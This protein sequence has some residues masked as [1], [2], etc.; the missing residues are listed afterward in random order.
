MMGGE[1]GGLVVEREWPRKGYC[2]F[3][4]LAL[5]LNSFCGSPEAPE[6]Y[7]HTSACL[8]SLQ[9]RGAGRPEMI[10]VLPVMAVVRLLSFSGLQFSHL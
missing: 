10:L 4:C 9:V 6:F 5:R 2:L 3:N 7:L 1:S 8:P